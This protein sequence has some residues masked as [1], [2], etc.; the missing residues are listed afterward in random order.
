MPSIDYIK[1]F[2]S[3][4]IIHDTLHRIDFCYLTEFF[5]FIGLLVCEENIWALLEYEDTTDI[6]R[7]TAYS[8]NLYVGNRKPDL[9]CLEKT[10][11]TKE[12]YENY[13]RKLPGKTVYLYDIIQNAVSEDEERHMEC[14]CH[15]NQE[16]QIILLNDILSQLLDI[17][18]EGEQN[19]LK[20]DC[21]K[22]LIEI[23]VN[24][25]IWFYSMNLQYFTKRESKATIDAKKAFIDSHDYVKE[26]Q[27]IWKE[28]DIEYIY[29]YA[30]LWC[31]VRA[32]AAC[33][34]PNGIPYYPIESLSERCIQYCR[35]YPEFD[36]ARILLGLCYEPSLKHANDALIAFNEVIQNVENECFLASVYYWMGK[37]YETFGDREKETKLCYERANQCKLKFR[38][39]FKLA[40]IARN[41]GDYD[42]TINLFQK[43]IT[44]LDLKL[45]LHLI[46]PLELEYLFKAYTQ[47]SYAYLQ[48]GKY[49]KA[50]ETGKK[51][52]TVKKT[53]IKES[54][55]FDEFYGDLANQYREILSERLNCD[56][57]NGLV[58]ESENRRFEEKA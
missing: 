22:K 49:D 23:Y 35:K 9:M 44:K 55:Y 29:E 53:E 27:H 41:E 11:I 36:N 33:D 15:Y 25:K 2:R 18:F 31:E 28:T 56:T 10:G 48:I 19:A 7:N 13:I 46:D 32:N 54:K 39:Y 24:Q 1:K 43:I 50:I 40:V 26:I 16:K 38:T 34:F 14:I 51:A 6:E 37:R 8:V 47:Q 42:K 57:A 21:L 4:K 3:I 30:M 12:E 52:L 20:K 5:R 58:K 45:Y 17:V